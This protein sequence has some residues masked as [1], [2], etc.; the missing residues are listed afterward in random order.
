MQSHNSYLEDVVEGDDNKPRYICKYPEFMTNKDHDTRK[1]CSLLV[2]CAPTGLLYDGEK[3]VRDPH[4]QIDKSLNFY[5]CGCRGHGISKV[6]ELGYPECTSLSVSDLVHDADQLAP[7]L[8]AFPWNGERCLCPEGYVNT[9]DE[10]GLVASGYKKTLAYDLVSLPETCVRRP[11]E[12]DARTGDY[13]NRSIIRNDAYHK[14]AYYDRDEKNCKCNVTFS[15]LGIYVDEAGNGN[16]VDSEGCNACI[17]LK[18]TRDDA[19]HMNAARLSFYAEPDGLPKLWYE[20]SDPDEGALGMKVRSAIIKPLY[21]P[22]HHNAYIPP[23]DLDQGL[24]FEYNYT[25]GTENWAQ[26]YLEDDGEKTPGLMTVYVEKGERPV[27][28]TGDII[29][30]P[31]SMDNDYPKDPPDVDRVYT[32]MIISGKPDFAT[33][34][35]TNSTKYITKGEVVNLPTH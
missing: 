9:K 32:E 21:N 5:R 4:S 30:N 18:S 16:A 29:K 7:C 15:Y 13:L 23:I 35:T 26:K 24:A 25:R 22:L 12:F 11:C 1:P 19:V 31:K 33:L 20:L 3:L 34:I 17:A 8:G 27:Y 6:T 10:D 2:G 28:K 14:P